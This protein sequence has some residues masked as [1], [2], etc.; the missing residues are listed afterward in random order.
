M[1][2]KMIVNWKQI[3]FHFIKE[4][5]EPK[6]DVEPDWIY[7]EDFEDDEEDFDFGEDILLI[8]QDFNQDPDPDRDTYN[9]TAYKH[10]DQKVKPVPGTFLEDACALRQ[11]P[12]DPLLSLPHLS[13][14]LP[15]FVSNA[16]FTME[17]LEALEINP[18]GF[19]LP[20]EEKLFNHVMFLNQEAL[21]FEEADCGT[22]KELYFSPYIIPTIPHVPWEYKNIP[23]PPG[24]R[25]KVIE[26]FKHKIS[27]GVYE[28][29]QSAYRLQW[30][31]VLKKSGKLR[32][33]HDLQPLNKVTICDA[34]LLPIVDD[35]IESFAGQQCY[36][37]FDLFWGFDAHKLHP[38]SQ[39]ITTFLTP[40]GLLSTHITTYR[41]HQFP[42]RIPALYDLYTA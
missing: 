31:C 34:G 32:I 3:C 15:N 42:C 37:V 13:P 2:R 30:F 9:F 4:V 26:V 28:P 12:E 23:I 21:S 38:S 10:V 40:L 20:M 6:K 18:S 11:F 24:I 5:E 29:S 1:L 36:T 35:F 19:L 25:D 8:P 22:F 17:C 7:P 16:K 33:V 14:N 41:I 27:A 39:D